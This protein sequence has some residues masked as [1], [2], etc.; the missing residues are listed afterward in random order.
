MTVD[1]A[2][3]WRDDLYPKWLE[4]LK[5]E[6]DLMGTSNVILIPLGNDVSDFVEKADLPYNI[7]PKMMHYSRQAAKKRKELPNKYPEEFERFE[8][9][10]NKEL[11]LKSAQERF[12]TLFEIENQIFE[13]PVPEILIHGRMKALKAKGPDSL[14][15]KR[16]LFTYKKHLEGLK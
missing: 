6:I 1:N 14:S 13:T 8:P 15:R 11:L 2:G 4:L 5:K 9:T 7:G 16:L 10:I 12:T 3:K